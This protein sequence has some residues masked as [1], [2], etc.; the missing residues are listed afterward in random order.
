MYSTVSVDSSYDMESCL[1]M[2]AMTSLF[3]D[4]HE[5]ERRE[6]SP[7]LPFREPPMQPA[8]NARIVACNKENLVTL[9]VQVAVG[10][11]DVRS[12]GDTGR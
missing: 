4:G 12:L 9:Q 3:K 10:H 6:A 1:T 2:I 7:D 5:L 8:E 11:L